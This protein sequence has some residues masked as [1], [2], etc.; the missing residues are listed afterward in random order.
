MGGD[1]AMIA[2]GVGCK[3][4]CASETIVALVR[5]ALTAA[6][7]ADAP[8]TLF[9]H[10]DKAS[11]AGLRAAAEQLALPL[12]FLPLETLRQASGRVATHSSRVMAI[13]GVP[14]IAETAALAGAGASAILLAPRMNQGGASCAVARAGETVP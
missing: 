9:T 14:S 11:E 10:I 6:Q 12:V 5:R 1:E 3:K 7:C 4:G 13:F 2:V 8:A